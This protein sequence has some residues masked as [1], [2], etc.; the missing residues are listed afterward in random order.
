MRNLISA[1]LLIAALAGCQAVPLVAFGGGDGSTMETAVVIE[2]TQK[3]SAGV[4]AEYAWL[5]R[6]YPGYRRIS[7]ALLHD[8]GKSYDLFE[9]EA[10]GGQRRNVY[11]DISAFFGRF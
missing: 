7:Q 3:S 5:G 6:H 11:F 9:L 2:T 4:Q 10:P 1:L 8:G